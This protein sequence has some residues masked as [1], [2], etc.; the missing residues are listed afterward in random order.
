MVEWWDVL[1]Q[2]AAMLV[3]A[4]A[5]WGGVPALVDWLKRKT[6]WSGDAAAVLAW[7]CS[8][9]VALLGLLAAGQV[10]PGH[11]TPERLPELVLMVLLASQVAYQRRKRS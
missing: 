7:L 3:A 8:A 1:V 6:G 2:I 4:V 11:F 10:A 9:L 5:G